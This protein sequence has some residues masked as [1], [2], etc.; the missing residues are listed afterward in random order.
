MGSATATAYARARAHITRI[1]RSG[2]DAR[3]LRLEVL[4]VV[5]R[6]VGFDAY[7]WLITDPETSVG[8][9]PLAD[10]PCLPVLPQ[11]IRLKYLSTLNRWTGLPCGAVSLS[12]AAGGDLSRSLMWRE[13]LR[14]YQVSDIASSAY[15]DRFGCWGFLDL[16]RAQAPPFAGHDIEFLTCIA[17]P[18][19][20]ALRRSQ[21]K[22]F[23]PSTAADKL[24]AGP[25]VLLLSSALQVRAQTPQT[26]R[27]LRVLVPPEAEEQAPVPASAYNVAAQLLA[28]EAGAD[29]NPPLARV[30][31]ASGRWLTL[32]AARMDT[33][34]PPAERDIAVSVEPA[35]P[36]D[37]A[38]VF[39]RAFGLT[40]RETQ[41]L[42]HLVTGA[43]TS[44]LAQHLFVSENTI[45]DHLKSI[46]TKT[47]TRNRRTLLA[48]ALGT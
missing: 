33:A 32:R 9:S 46:F 40:P 24:P 10:V 23:G 44:G 41:L 39:A 37:R 3:A 19:T 42:D 20:A 1:C 25:V 21:A 34:Q 2:A 35:A 17:G 26:R 18:V 47:A 5:R 8:S 29:T 38:V 6:V 36:H 30:H 31:L 28:A 15:R 13:L 14:S 16:W 11:L 22:T 45:Q 27:Y 7:A 48:R 12:A 4:A 43:S